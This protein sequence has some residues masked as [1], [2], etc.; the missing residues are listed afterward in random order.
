MSKIIPIG[1]GAKPSKMELLHT[2]L[3]QKNFEVLLGL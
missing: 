1:T 3:D 2:M